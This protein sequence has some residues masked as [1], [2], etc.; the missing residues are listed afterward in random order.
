MIAFFR[1]VKSSKRMA[2]SPLRVKPQIHFPP[3]VTCKTVPKEDANPTT[4]SRAPSASRLRFNRISTFE[5]QSYR[6]KLSEQKNTAMISFITLFQWTSQIF[7]RVNRFKNSKQCGLLRAYGTKIS[8]F[9]GDETTAL[10]F[11]SFFFFSAMTEAGGFL[12]CS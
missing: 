4:L 11:P 12:A 3:T 1:V 2:E 10:C 5:C 7:N 8:A 6:E 9:C